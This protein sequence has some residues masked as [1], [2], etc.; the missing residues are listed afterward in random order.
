M[1]SI[2]DELATMPVILEDALQSNLTGGYEW[3]SQAVE[4]FLN[5]CHLTAKVGLQLPII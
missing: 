5:E 2:E 3:Q 1:I 4:L